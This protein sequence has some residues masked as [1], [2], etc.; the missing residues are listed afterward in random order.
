MAGVEGIDKYLA[1]QHL[2]ALIAPTMPPSW[3]V[4]IV[5]GDHSGGGVS[6]MPAIAGY[7]HLTIPMGYSRGLPVGL[8]F[9]GAAWSDANILALGAAYEKASHA[10]HAPAYRSASEDMAEQDGALAPVKPN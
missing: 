7:P 6:T 1:D 2:D 5:G 8:S 3:R 10:R 4:D 9:I